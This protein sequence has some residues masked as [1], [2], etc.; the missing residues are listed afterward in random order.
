[1][2]EV[3][4]WQHKKTKKRVRVL[5]WWETFDP[6]IDESTGLVMHKLRGVKYKIG[7]LVQ[8]GW[9]IETEYGYWF[10]VGPKA[11]KD[12]KNLGLIKD[13]TSKVNKKL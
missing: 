3:Y 8:I 13:E 6:I 10:G 4:Q 7:A 1:M 12:F 2:I 5:P 11:K 9:L